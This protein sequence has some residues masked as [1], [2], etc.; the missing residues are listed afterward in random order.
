M[1]DIYTIKTANKLGNFD[2]KYGQRWWGTVDEAQ[3]EVSWNT[4]NETADYFP[5]Q[6]I[7]FE[8]RLMKKTQGTAEKPS[9]DYLFLRK[10]KTIGGPQGVSSPPAAQ[11]PENPQDAT[12]LQNIESKLDEVLALLKVENKVSE[13]VMDDVVADIGDGEINLADIPF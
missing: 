12:T 7:E 3:F 10:V 6:K 9:R 4:M 1:S 13:K 11:S 8:E 5:G 2:A